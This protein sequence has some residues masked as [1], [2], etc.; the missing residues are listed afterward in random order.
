M[1]RTAQAEW[2]NVVATIRRNKGIDPPAVHDE[3]VIVSDAAT[4]TGL[5]AVILILPSG[6]IL[7]HAFSIRYYHSINDMEAQALHQGLVHFEH[8]LKN[9][10]I[11]YWGDNTSVLWTLLSTSAQSYH[12]NIWVGR[13]IA[14]VARMKSILSSF[15]VPSL[16][17]PS[18]APSR[19]ES[20]TREHRQCL[21]YCYK[22]LCATR[23][24]RLRGVE[25]WRGSAADPLRPRGD[26]LTGI[27]SGPEPPWL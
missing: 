26:L 2:N 22:T 23:S 25:C 14:A 11:L 3:I 24:A 20:F 21:S 1:W 8:V 12:L 10:H 27:R 5:G 18:D 9:R 15:Y 16:F 4:E 19:R 6:R 13:I 7:Q 17:N